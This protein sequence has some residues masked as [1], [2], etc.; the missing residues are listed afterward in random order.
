MDY[1]LCALAIGIFT[2]R[3]K[4]AKNNLIMENTYIHE[5]AVIDKGAKIG[6]GTKI[7]HFC[8]VMGTAKIGENCVLGQNV[9]VGNNVKLGNNT[10][11]QNNVSVYEGVVCED[12]V[13]LGPSMVFTNVTNPRSAVNR[14]NEFKTTRVKKGAT[15]GANATV[16]CGIEIGRFAFIGAG[17]VVTKS[18]AAYALVKGSPAKQTGWMSEQGDKLKFDK[19]GE[20]ICKISG[21]KYKRKNNLVEKMK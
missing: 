9:F 11:I 2:Q 16:L 8:H 1:N 7:W 12:D 20:A 17:A 18:V 19:N 6:N 5:T 13:F 4:D 14:K 10:K 15:I 3:R 21:E